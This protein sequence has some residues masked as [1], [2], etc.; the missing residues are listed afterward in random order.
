LVVVGVFSVGQNGSYGYDF[1]IFHMA[2]KMLWGGLNYWEELSVRPGP[3]AYPPQASALIAFYALFSPS[4]A[5]TIHT[6]INFACVAV[7]V[8]VVNQWFIKYDYSAQL[9]VSQGLCIA[10]LIG[11]PLSAVTM[12][13]GQL[14]FILLA[15]IVL[16]WHSYQSR[17]IV[18]AGL[19]LGVCTI[20]PQMSIALI[21]WLLLEKE[22]I[23]LSIGAG[24][25]CVLMVPTFVYV[26]IVESFLSW[27]F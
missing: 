18:F 3:Y 8:Y 2:G 4:V 5:L 23:I 11:N 22:F 16:F 25:A 13:M 10:I 24:F 21:V 19:L 12:H 15:A 27:I 26:G 1:T 17:K 7:V 14:N 6:V 9:S 20:K